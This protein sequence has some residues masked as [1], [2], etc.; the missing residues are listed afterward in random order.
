VAIGDP[1]RMTQAVREAKDYSADERRQFQEAFR[2][3]AARHRRYQRIADV[4]ALVTMGCGLLGAV[5][6]FHILRKPVL[7]WTVVPFFAMIGVWI[8]LMII[9]PWI[10]C[11]GCS[12]K[13]ERRFGDYCPEC[14]SRSLIPPRGINPAHCTTCGMSGNLGRGRRRCRIR[15]CTHC[16]LRLDEKGL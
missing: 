10:L 1:F 8:V 16:G 7:Q 6:E 11:P 3:L 2:P 4:W 5:L 12:R 15:N 14:G 9:T 13:M